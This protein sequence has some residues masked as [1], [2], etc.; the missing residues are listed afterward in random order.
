MYH[1]T[2]Y[3]KTSLFVLMIVLVSCSRDNDNAIEDGIY[4]PLQI[5]DVSSDGIA[6]KGVMC[7]SIVGEV[8]KR[9]AV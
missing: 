1:W 3:I 8:W 7:W 2:N 6:F 4:V 9:N 5:G